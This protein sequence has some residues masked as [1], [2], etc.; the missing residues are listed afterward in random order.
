MKITCLHVRKVWF[1]NLFFFGSLPV[2]ITLNRCLKFSTLNS[3]NFG[4]LIFF[5]VGLLCIAQHKC[6][7]GLEEAII[8][9]FCF[10]FCYRITETSLLSSL[11]FG[12]E[13]GWLSSFY[14]CLIKKVICSLNYLCSEYK[15]FRFPLLLVHF[16]WSILCQLFFL[17]AV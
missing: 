14:S 13:D 5:S 2:I 15:H 11:Q 8:F 9:N 10:F 1:N 3:Q 16:L 7:H 17:N 6:C 4:F 12:P